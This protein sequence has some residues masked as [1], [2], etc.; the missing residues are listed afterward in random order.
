MSGNSEGAIFHHLR[1]SSQFIPQI[2]AIDPNCGDTEVRAFLLETYAYMV[3]VANITVNIQ[4]AYSVFALG[5]C[6]AG[7][8][9]FQSCQASG[10]MFGF[11]RDLITLIPSICTLGYNRIIEEDTGMDSLESAACYA[12]LLWKLENWKESPISEAS[13]SNVNDLLLAAKLYKEA[14]L[15]FLHAAFYASKVT[16]PEF[17]RLVDTSLYAALSSIDFDND[18]PVLPV[19][20]WPSMIMGS[21]LRDPMQRE[22]L[23]CKMLQTTFNM[24]VVLNSVQLLD[25]LWEDNSIDAYGPY[26]LGS[27]MKKHGIIHSMS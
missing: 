12:D 24:T 26:G 3:S 27:V 6:I 7:L 25:W 20:L 9:R 21:C 19:M 22:Y 5:P 10:M 2:L 18:S 15:I 23:R 17:L 4:P 16:D 8:E 13:K 1:A 11:A 14:I